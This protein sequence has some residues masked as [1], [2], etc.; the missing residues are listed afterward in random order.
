MSVGG[1]YIIEE[2]AYFIYMIRDW[3]QIFQIP[4]YSSVTQLPLHVENVLLESLMPR[5]ATALILKSPAN[6]LAGI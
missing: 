6:N 5:I 3:I 1:F 4:R 2:K